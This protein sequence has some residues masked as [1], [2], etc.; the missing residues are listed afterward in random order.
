MAETNLKLL[1]IA[2][3]AD[4]LGVSSNT[5]YSMAQNGKIPAFKLAG[6]WRVRPEALEA[7]LKQQAKRAEE[8]AGLGDW[9]GGL[10][11]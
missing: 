9:S 4:R 11:K 5:A 3:V 7:W 8:A 10:V 1:R 6:K 2:D